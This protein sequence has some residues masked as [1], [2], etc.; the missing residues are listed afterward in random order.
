M[1]GGAEMRRT[2]SGLSIG[3]PWY[4]SPEQIL[5]PRE[6]DQRTDIYA[7]GIVLYEMLTGGVPFDAESDFGVKD[8]QIRAPAKNPREKHPEISEGVAAVVLKAMAKDAGNR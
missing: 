1:T 3:S 2:A 8:Q 6:V 4:M 5:R 7:L